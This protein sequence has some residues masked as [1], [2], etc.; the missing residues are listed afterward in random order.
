M[1]D[2]TQILYVSGNG[3]AGEIE[4][5][6]IERPN[7]GADESTNGG[8]GSPRDR[9]SSWS[10][11]IKTKDFGPRNIDLLSGTRSNVN[12]TAQQLRIMIDAIPAFAWSCPGGAELLS[13]R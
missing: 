4:R 5:T 8:V 11:G 12:L 10:S 1:L 3:R 6:R 9:N 7:H 13:A 2:A